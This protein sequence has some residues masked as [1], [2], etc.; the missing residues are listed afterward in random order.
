[1]ADT[2]YRPFSNGTQFDDWQAYNCDRCTQ[3]GRCDLEDIL[4]I[5]GET[6]DGSVSEATARMCGYLNDDGSTARCYVWPCA[7]RRALKP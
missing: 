1:M 2:P 5:G 4:L 3:S 6:G 7:A